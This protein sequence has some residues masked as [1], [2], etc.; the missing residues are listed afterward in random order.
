[1][2]TITFLFLPLFT[3]TLLAQN[4]VIDGSFEN[5]NKNFECS[6]LKISQSPD[7][8]V[9]DF[10]LMEE[11]SMAKKGNKAHS[12]KNYLGMFLGYA[13]EFTLGQLQAEMKKGKQYQVSMFVCQ[14]K[15][16]TYRKESFKALSVW[17]LD[18]IPKYPERDTKKSFGINSKFI[19]LKGIN[20]YI[21]EEESWEQVSGT[22]KAI[23]GE[24]YILLG[25]FKGANLDVTKK[26]GNLYYYF[27]DISVI[28]D[29]S[30][31]EKFEVGVPIVLEY[32]FFE[33][34][35]AD[36]IPSSFPALNKLVELLNENEGQKV[37]IW[38]HTDNVGDS[39]KNQQLS[40]ARA[41]AVYH[42]LLEK[43]IDSKLLTFKGF[44]ET[45]PVAS[46]DSSEN[47]QKNRRVEFVFTE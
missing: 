25:N 35:R 26:A 22:Y 12:G 47:R 34:G 27:D 39:T 1:M 44:G 9:G 2:K 41:K 20:E 18:T 40:E 5:C 43:G 37:E 7:L 10:E 21:N 42:Y 19:L 4:L 15:A 38:G 32:I 29:T 31:I 16:F 30:T 28:E 13:G 23:G 46:N 6:W 36:L 8:L 24:K 33:N 45:K 14:S 11:K 3:S 17:F